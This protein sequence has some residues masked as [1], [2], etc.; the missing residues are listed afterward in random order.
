[1]KSPGDQFFLALYEDF[2]KEFGL[3]RLYEDCLERFLFRVM[4]R[5]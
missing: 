5:I 2:G 1:M 4:E 3:L